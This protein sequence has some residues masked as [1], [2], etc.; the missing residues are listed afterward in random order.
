MD[1]YTFFLFWMVICISLILAFGFGFL[2]GYYILCNPSN[3]RKTNKK[4]RTK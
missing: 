2:Y 1:I 3:V 4:H